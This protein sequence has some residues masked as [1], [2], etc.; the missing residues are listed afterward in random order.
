[1]I[2]FS[3]ANSSKDYRR[4]MVVGRD[5]AGQFAAGDRRIIGVMAESHLQEGQQKLEHGK[6]PAY[7]LSITDACLGWDDS[8]QLL[9][10]LAAAVQ[11]RRKHRYNEEELVPAKLRNG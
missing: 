3:H 7:G 1:M 4:Q 6:K 11:E 8:A 5:V 10:E 9:R 2:D